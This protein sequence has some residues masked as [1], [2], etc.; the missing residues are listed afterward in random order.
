MT[1]KRADGFHN[2]ESIFYP[3]HF[4][5]VLEILPADSFSFHGH[6]I[7]VTGKTS[8]NLCVKAYELLRQQHDLP[9][10]EMHLLKNIPA[11][12]GL[13]GGS[14]DASYTLKLLNEVFDLNI[15]RPQLEKYAAQLGS[16]CPFFIANT[17]AYI[18]GRGE[19]LEPVDLSLKGYYI[20]IVHPGI[21]IS[22]RE[23]FANLK[24]SAADI[25]IKEIIKKPVEQWKDLLRNDFEAYAFQT[26]PVLTEIKQKLYDAGAIYASMS[27][28]GSA[29]Y[30]IAEKEISVSLKDFTV[31]K[32]K[33]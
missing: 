22:T 5:D 25:S 20:T 3:V 19:M 10:V 9:A 27:G 26:Y 6:G 32:G 24:P 4:E 11:G 28:S 12:A 23:A 21:H 18:S 15:D 17:S 30:G 29:V 33:L 7:P 2:I 31:W 16:D 14:S 8:D 1:G 13:G